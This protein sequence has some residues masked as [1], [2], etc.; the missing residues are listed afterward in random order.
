MNLCSGGLDS[1]PPPAV[2]ADCDADGGAHGRGHD[3][4]RDLDLTCRGSSR[5][6]Y[7][8]ANANGYEPTSGCD[9]GCDSGFACR[10]WHPSKTSPTCRCVCTMVQVED[11]WWG[12]WWW[13]WMRRLLLLHV[14]AAA[15]AAQ[16]FAQPH[17]SHHNSRHANAPSATANKRI[18]FLDPTRL[19]N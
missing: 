13:W 10:R 7:A 4:G 3:F 11:G 14:V 9:S 12:S 16:D 5:N 8:G 19:F 6:C 2:A 15:A 18:A 1:S 17:N